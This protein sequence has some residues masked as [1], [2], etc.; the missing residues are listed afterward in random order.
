[1]S[2]LQVEALLSKWA[3]VSARLRGPQLLLSEQQASMEVSLCFRSNNR[4][5]STVNSVDAAVTG[6]KYPGRL[7][8]S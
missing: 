4:S 3:T 7:R 2:N 6:G 5:A 1:M 8:N